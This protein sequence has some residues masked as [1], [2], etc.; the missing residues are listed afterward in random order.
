MEQTHLTPVRRVYVMTSLES[1]QCVEK[2]GVVR[3]PARA[4]GIT[5]RYH[6]YG[7]I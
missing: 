4:V 6:L 2:D 7:I 5:C 1:P 3:P